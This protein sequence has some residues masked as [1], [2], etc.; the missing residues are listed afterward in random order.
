MMLF[1]QFII[2]IKFLREREAMGGN[3]YKHGD[4]SSITKSDL[5]GN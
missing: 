4:F 1:L 5:R 3:I 2:I